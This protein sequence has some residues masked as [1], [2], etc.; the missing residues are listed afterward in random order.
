MK[1][2]VL[3][4]LSVVTLVMATL[5]VFAFAH[6]HNRGTS[7]ALCSTQGCNTVGIHK[8]GGTY[9]SGHSIGDGHDYHQVCSVQGCTKTVNHMHDGVTCFPHNNVGGQS[10]HNGHGGNGHHH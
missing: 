9:Y 3:I 8:H 4:L 6:G 2:K 7:Y 5:P 1:K 10:Y